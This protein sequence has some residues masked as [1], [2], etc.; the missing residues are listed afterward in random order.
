MNANLLVK[1]TPFSIEN[2][3]FT[4]NGSSKFQWIHPFF[5]HNLL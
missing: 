5:N 2:Y 1:V 3:D 4:M